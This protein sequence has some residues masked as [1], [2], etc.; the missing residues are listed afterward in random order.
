MATTKIFDVEFEIVKAAPA[1]PAGQSGN[2]YA[3]RRGKRRATVAAASGHPA[4]ILTVLNADIT[5]NA[6]ETIEILHSRPGLVTGG[7]GGQVLS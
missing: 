7:E 5:V 1:L 3:Y 4:D 2:A 6:G